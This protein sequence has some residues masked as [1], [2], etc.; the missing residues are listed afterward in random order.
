MITK[1]LYIDPGTGSMLFS[2][3]IGI[4]GILIFSLRALFIKLKFALSGG[5]VDTKDSNRLPICI[6]SEGKRY[7]NVFRPICDE[8]EKRGKDIWYLT[9]S[10]DDP[11][12][13]A[14]YK[15]VHAEFIGEGNKAISKMNLI[16]ADIV[17]ST[18]P[19]LDVY[20]WKRSKSASYYIHIPH[21]PNDITTYKMLGLDFYD[22]ILLSGK[23][24]EEEIRRIEAVRKIPAKETAFIGI[25]YLDSMKKRLD[26]AAPVDKK[27]KKATVLLAPS[28]GVNGILT[29]Y[30]AEFIE[31][32]LKTDYNIIIRPHPQSFTSE[33]ELM[34]SLI[35]KF[36]ESDR[37]KWN[38]DADNFD[39]LNEADI[40]ISDFSGVV[41]DFS[42]VFNKP[43]IYTEPSMDWSQYDCS[44][45]SE[46]LWTYKILPKIGR[47]LSKDNFENIGSLIED[48]IS[49]KESADLAAGRDLARKETWCDIGCGAEK[50]TDYLLK[51]HDEITAAA[52]R[53]A[54]EKNKA[55]G[56]RS[57]KKAKQKS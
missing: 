4:A 44:W 6:F 11:A 19:G 30:G 10:P 53:A 34:D 54:A 33:K 36:P 2:I 55:A 48:C 16:N 13:T 17:L 1:F 56:S 18:T 31:K 5:K 50:V 22:A 47:K 51:K 7:W 14:G 32:L 12:L 37:L 28:W 38:R 23:Y 15:H 26:G 8:F 3:I 46:E 49:G 39:V 20:Q 40:L 52:K 21:M 24:Q 25:P 29:A 9:A 43:I 45:D 42:I 41:F 57:K 27:D 35:Q